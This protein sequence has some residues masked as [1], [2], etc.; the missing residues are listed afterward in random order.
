MVHSK[1]PKDAYWEENDGVYLMMSHSNRNIAHFTEVFNFVYHYL[2]HTS[3]YP[4]METVYFLQYQKEAIY[5]WIVSYI[6][7]AQ[8]I[9]PSESVFRSVF[10]EEMDKLHKSGMICFRKAVCIGCYTPFPL[11]SHF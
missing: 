1:P 8:S 9:F 4:T 6:E 2:H 5:P 3:L 10:L 7:V 11:T